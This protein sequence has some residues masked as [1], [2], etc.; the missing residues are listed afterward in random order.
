MGFNDFTLDAL[1][2]D[3]SEGMGA[4]QYVICVEHNLTK[5]PENLI[6]GDATGITAAQRAI[7]CLRLA[8]RGDVMMGPMWFTR[9]GRFD[10]GVRS[11]RLRGGW[12]LPTRRWFALRAHKSNRTRGPFSSAHPATLGG[13]R[14]WKRTR[15]PRSGSEVLHLKL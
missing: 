4:S 10:F 12:T 15:Q 14:L 8:S 9:S 7:T 5:S 11:G 3:W 6:L 1:T 2:D 13:A